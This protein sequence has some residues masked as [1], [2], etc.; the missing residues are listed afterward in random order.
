M[1]QTPLWH[2]MSQKGTIDT[3]GKRTIKVH[4]SVGDSKRVIVAV[5]ITASR[6]QLP[7][8][9]SSKV[10]E[11]VC[12]Q[13]F[14]TIVLTFGCRL[15]LVGK[16]K[17]RIAKK[18]IATLPDGAF[19]R[20]NEKAWFTEAVMLDWVKL[21]LAPW[22]AKALPGIVPILLRDQFN[23]LTTMVADMRPHKNQA[24]C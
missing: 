24:L 4:T 19:Y 23:S 10:S 21:I 12:I 8:I 15:S 1:D 11:D 17:G 3:I 18:E 20:V 16:P 6:S 13:I 9:L 7:S 14:P 2:A 22:A 5:M